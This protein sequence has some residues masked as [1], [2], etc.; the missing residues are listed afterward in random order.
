[1]S[2]DSVASRHPWLVPFLSLRGIGSLIDHTLLK[3]EAGESEIIALADEALRFGFGA[4]C[5]NGQWVGSAARRLGDSVAR[6][7]AVGVVAVVGFPL[8]ASGIRAKVAETRAA[9]ADGA[10]EIDMVMSLGWAKAGAWDQVARE[11]AEVVEAAEGR[12]V[13]VILETAALSDAEVARGSQTAVDAGAGMVKTSTGFHPAGGATVEAVRRIRAAVG[14]RA[15]VKASGGIRTSSD[16]LRMLAAGASRLGSSTAVGWSE[17]LGP[18]AP[19]LGDLLE[20][21]V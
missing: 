4:V 10:S 9:A 18:G 12:L 16:A 11:I 6:H 20:R 1:M 14:S 13:K 5:V 19:S 8:G 15:G 21:A 17:V 7:G 2:S 3:P